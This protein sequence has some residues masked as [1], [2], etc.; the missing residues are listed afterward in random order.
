MDPCI[1]I[2]LT[3]P[4][5]PFKFPVDMPT[6]IHTMNVGEAFYHSTA[7]D[8]VTWVV[9]LSRVYS[10]KGDEGSCVRVMRAVV[11]WDAYDNPS[12]MD[13]GA[14]ICITGILRLLVDVV[15]IPPLP[16]LVATTLGSFSLDDC[17]SK[18]GLIL[19]TL[20]DGLVYYQPCYYCKNATKTIISPE[21]I[22]AASDTLVHWT[23]EGH[24]GDAP[25]SIWFTSNSG[26]YSITLELKK[27]DGLYYCPTDVYTVDH[28]SIQSP[29]PVMQ[30]IL[31]PEPKPLP[32]R[33]KWYMPVT[34]NHMTE[35]EVWMLC[36]GSLGEQQLDMLPGNVMSIP[37]GFQYHPFWFI[38]WKEEARIQKQAALRSAERTTECKRWY[39]R[40]FSFMQASTSNFSQPTRVALSYDGFLAYLLS[41]DEALQHA[42]VFLT[43]T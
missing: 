26:L 29:I 43:N 18:R 6:T 14:N 2:W 3:S 38:D 41:I 21:A 9:G 31:A 37:P 4:T 5:T 11:G 25:E 40:D 20:S 39:F 17:C 23:Q 13:G 16:T 42:W 32:K 28:N 1:L 22:L 19:L 36:L 27:Q 12:L 8:S 33:S 7:M 30:W 10:L 35:S 24:K 15:S 34:C